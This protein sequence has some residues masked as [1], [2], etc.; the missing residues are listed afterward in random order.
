L[1]PP[2]HLWIQFEFAGRHRRSLHFLACGERHTQ[3]LRQFRRA[4]FGA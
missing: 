3:L 4:A 1:I 2:E